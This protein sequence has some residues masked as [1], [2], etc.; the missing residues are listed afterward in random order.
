MNTMSKKQVSE[1]LADNQNNFIS[2]TFIKKD[3]TK[4]TLNGR[5]NVKKGV[6]G[7]ERGRISSEALRRQGYVTI[8]TSDGY[9]CFNV[10]QV[11]SIKAN[12]ALYIA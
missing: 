11:I 9:K 8:K 3:G 10:E 4:R 6:K 2:L 7:N 5:M 12:G 1:I